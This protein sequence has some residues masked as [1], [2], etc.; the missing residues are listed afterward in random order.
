M[1]RNEKGQSLVELALV[2]PL[3]LLL[4]VGLFDFGRIFYTYTHLH[5]ASQES[6]RL[7]GLG[8]SDSEV[9]QFVKD[10]IHIGDPADLQVT[11]S[12]DDLTRFSGDYVTV[13]LKLPA[14]IVTPMMASLFPSPFY[15]ETESTIR[16]E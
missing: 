2:L 9:T 3:V 5:L 14:T 11:I 7:A 4:L 1:V 8:K 15:I 16:V 13:Q 12:P 6:V 10:Y